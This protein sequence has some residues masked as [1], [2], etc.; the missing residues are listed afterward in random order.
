MNNIEV[1]YNNKS[2]KFDTASEWNELTNEQVLLVCKLLSLSLPEDEFRLR[3]AFIMLPK[4]VRRI[5]IKR[6]RYLATLDRMFKKSA[7][8]EELT[9]LL[10]ESIT[11]ADSFKFLQEFGSRTTN[12][13]PEFRHNLRLY[14]GPADSLR[15]CS[16]LEYATADGKLREW[17]ALAKNGKHEQAAAA[18]LEAIAVFWRPKKR[19]IWLRKLFN[20]YNGDSRQTF[21]VATVTSRAKGL[22]NLP[23]E[24]IEAAMMFIDASYRHITAEFSEV[25]SDKGESSEGFGHAGLL[26]DLA[27]TKF[28][29][30]NETSA[31]S[32]YTLLLYCLKAVK[33]NEKLTEKLN[34]N[35]ENAC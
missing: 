27:G 15:N 3:A 11:L 26:L 22:R 31:T 5:I 10:L 6:Q 33:D 8:G 4:K 34:N 19:F 32:L 28:G 18:L 23:A 12:P 7:A 20:T 24:K 30:L 14:A 13:L 1:I 35:E 17:D 16:Y 29:T 21:N 2:Y 25:F 9:D